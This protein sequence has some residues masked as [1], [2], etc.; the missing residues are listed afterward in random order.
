MQAVSV[1]SYSRNSGST[2]LDT[3][4]GNPGWIDSMISAISRSWRPST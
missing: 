2:S 1:R 3:V 4:T